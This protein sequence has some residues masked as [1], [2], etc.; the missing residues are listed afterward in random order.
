MATET[1]DDDCLEGEASFF[2]KLKDCIGG[3][4]VSGSERRDKN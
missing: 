3:D 1:E 2:Q 4:S